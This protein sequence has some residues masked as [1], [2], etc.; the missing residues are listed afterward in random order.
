MNGVAKKDGRHYAICI[1]VEPSVAARS[2]ELSVDTR[3]DDSRQETTTRAIQSGLEVERGKDIAIKVVLTEDDG[4]TAV[5]AQIL[6]VKALVPVDMSQ[7]RLQALKAVSQ[8]CSN[9]T[10]I[11]TGRVPAQTSELVANLRLRDDTTSVRMYV[12]SVEL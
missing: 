5:A 12:V 8:Q 1:N 6:S 10:E 11:E 2:A 3:H 9:C 7:R 4:S